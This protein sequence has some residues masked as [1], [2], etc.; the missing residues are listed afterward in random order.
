M[1]RRHYRHGPR[2]CSRSITTHIP[3]LENT[4]HETRLFLILSSLFALT[5]MYNA[6]AETEI[7]KRN[8]SAVQAAFDAW[9]AGTGGHARRVHR[10][11]DQAL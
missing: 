10:H 7:E 8:K 9:R 3:T 11:G 5:A 1:A 6:T 2:R 4:S